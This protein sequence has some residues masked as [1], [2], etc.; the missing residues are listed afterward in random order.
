MNI[1]NFLMFAV[2]TLTFWQMMLFKMCF[3]HI[4]RTCSSVFIQ[5]LVLKQLSIP[6]ETTAPSML[7]LL[8]LI[9]LGLPLPWEMGGSV[10]PDGSECSLLPGNLC[11]LKA[12]R[13]SD[14]SWLRRRVW[15]SPV[16]SSRLWKYDQFQGT[17]TFPTAWLTFPC[18]SPPLHLKSASGWSA[19]PLYKHHLCVREIKKGWGGIQ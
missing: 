13:G 2:K 9:P 8:A 16:T 4:I 7:C 1:S 10:I 11:D 6:A 17:G 19:S 5:S 14:N 15:L 18:I 3:L 12:Q